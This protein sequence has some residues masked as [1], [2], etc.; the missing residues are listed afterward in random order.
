MGKEQPKKS[1]FVKYPLNALN[2]ERGMAL[3]I[4]MLM[5]IMVTTLGLT[6]IMA[7]STEVLLGRNKRV[8]AETLYAAEAGIQHALQALKGQNFDMVAAAN[9]GQ[10]WLT[11]NDFNDIV[12]L[13]YNIRVSKTSD[14]GKVAA[15]NNLFVTSTAIH[16]SG[17]AKTIEAEISNPALTLP[18]NASMSISGSF[19]RVRFNGNA[20]VNGDLPL[21]ETA[22]EGSSCAEDKVGIAVDSMDTYIDIE[23]KKKASD[24]IIGM[25]LSPSIQ[26]RPSDL[27][28]M[29]VQNTALLIGEKADRTIIV[30]DKKVDNDDMVWGT[31]DDPQVTVIMMTGEDARIKFNGNTSGYGTLIINSEAYKKGRV[32]FNGNFTWNGLIIITGDSGFDRMKANGNNSITGAIIL[33]NTSEDTTEENFKVKANGNSTI[34]YSCNAITQAVSNTPLVLTSWHEI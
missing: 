32:E 30:D 19:S 28:P 13:E 26:L 29:M 23:V 34:Q 1:N 2:N 5:L 7:T 18:V 27:S 4:S 22:V 33:A 10:Q 20:T 15:T 21:G 6:S 31:V 17:G 16:T 24:N 3:V 11:V 9:V 8:T 12:G 25:G 14:S